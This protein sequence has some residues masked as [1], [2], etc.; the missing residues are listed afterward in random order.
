[1]IR[2]A[3]AHKPLTKGLCPLGFTLSIVASRVK[4]IPF[5]TSKVVGIRVDDGRTMPS[6]GRV[7]T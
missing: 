2:G 6:T 1:M 7:L 4:V 3:Y 5:Q